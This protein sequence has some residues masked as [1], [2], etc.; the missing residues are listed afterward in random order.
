MPTPT[1]IL[2]ARLSGAAMSAATDVGSA[3]IAETG[4]VLKNVVTEKLN[5]FIQNPGKVSIVANRSAKEAVVDVKPDEDEYEEDESEDED[6]SED[7]EDE[8]ESDDEDDSVT[9]R[10]RDEDCPLPIAFDAFDNEKNLQCAAAAWRLWGLKESEADEDNGDYPDLIAQGPTGLVFVGN[11]KEFIN[12]CEH[13]DLDVAWTFYGFEL[14]N[15]DGEQVHYYDEEEIKDIKVSPSIVKYVSAQ[16]AEMCLGMKPSEKMFNDFHWDADEQVTKVLRTIPFM[17]GVPLTQLAVA[18]ALIYGAKKAGKYQLF[19]HE[20]GEDSGL[21][22]TLFSLPTPDGE[23]WP[24][25]MLI[26]GGNMRV[27]GRGI[28]D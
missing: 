21:K 7:E 6:A 9:Y 14:R 5:G 10:T 19:I 17:E 11:L 23:K 16:I 15:E 4:R 3:A 28:V 18:H 20:F 25:S 22:P 13:N 8:D 27:E 12:F 2:M 24:R 26:D 1:Q